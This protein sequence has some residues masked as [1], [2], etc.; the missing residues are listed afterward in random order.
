[1]HNA[2]M[3]VFFSLLSQKNVNVNARHIT[4]YDALIDFSISLTTLF[5]DVT[6]HYRDKMK[7]HRESEWPLRSV[8]Q[9]YPV[10]LDV[11]SRINRP[12]SKSLFTKGP[13]PRLFYP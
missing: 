6:N 5:F 1:M 4:I 7:S 8:F 11:I 13:L 9:M 12:G 2:F 10:Y 3:Y